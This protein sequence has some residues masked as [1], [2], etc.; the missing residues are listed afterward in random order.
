M[1]NLENGKSEDLPQFN[2][3]FDYV[4]VLKAESG[5]LF[6]PDKGI[7][8]NEYPTKIGKVQVIF[9]TKFEDLGLGVDVP[10]YLKIEVYGKAPSLEEAIKNFHIAAMELV[11]IVAFVANSYIDNARVYLAYDNTPEKEKREFF[12]CYYPQPQDLIRKARYADIRSFKLFFSCLN[13]TTDI[14][15]I[16]GAMGQYQMA[17]NN[18]ERGNEILAIEFLFIGAEILTPIVKRRLCEEKDFDSDA[19]A[20]YL[21][22]EKNNLILKLGE[23]TFL[24][25][26][27]IVIG[28]L[29]RQVTALNMDI[30]H[31][32][33]SVP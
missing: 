10:R 29:E 21:K 9:H 6:H 11:P 24:V 13:D 5:V 14:G 27:I 32:M 30:N 3:V 2:P 4:V 17:L 23:Y 15:R 25:V 20:K 22:I 8:V 19:L 16:R 1:R 26:I 33:R 28:K 18:W 31:L 7:R 12:Q